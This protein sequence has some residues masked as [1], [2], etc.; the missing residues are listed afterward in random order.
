MSEV[1]AIVRQGEELINSISE[2]LKKSLSIKLG[3]VEVFKRTKLEN[4]EKELREVLEEYKNY[5]NVNVEKQHYLATQGGLNDRQ[6]KQ[7]ELM[8]I[9]SQ[10]GT[11]DILCKSYSDTI[12]AHRSEVNVYTG[13]LI[14]TI[15]LVVAITAIV[16]NLTK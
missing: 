13:N 2:K 7:G 4:E 12:S 9:Q 14:A 10:K 6:S 3:L 1:Q 5:V 8:T 16:L 15:A 11:I